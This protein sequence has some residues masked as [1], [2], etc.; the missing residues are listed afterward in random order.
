MLSD[1]L[2]TAV[3]AIDRYVKNEPGCYAGIAAQITLVR[4]AI[5]NLRNEIDCGPVRGLEQAARDGG[6]V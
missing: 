5:D 2:N 3:E 1:A 6:K 4:E